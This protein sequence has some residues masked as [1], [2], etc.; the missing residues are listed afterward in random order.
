LVLGVVAEQ[1]GAQDLGLMALLAPWVE[2]QRL[3]LTPQVMAA[4]EDSMGLLI[5]PPSQ[6]VMAAAQ[7][8]QVTVLILLQTPTTVFLVVL[9]L[10]AHKELPGVQVAPVDMVAAQAVEILSAP[11]ERVVH[12]HMAAVAAAV[13]EVKITQFLYL[14][15]AVL[16]ALLQEHL[17]AEEQPVVRA[18]VEAQGVSAKA[19]EAVVA[20]TDLAAL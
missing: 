20:L 3:A 7:C 10:R 4:Q 15:L 2:I 5:T 18:L 1:L 14:V 9:A 17:V 13:A 8:G 16:A 6:A 19:A 11:V 12:P